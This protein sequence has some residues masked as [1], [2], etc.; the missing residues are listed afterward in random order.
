MIDRQQLLAACKRRYQLIKVPGL[1]DVR[2]RSLTELE[3]STYEA[4]F[5]SGATPEELIEAKRS[6]VI[7][8]VV[9]ADGNP[10]LTTA[11]IKALGEVDGAI[12]GSLFTQCKEFAGIGTTEARLEE[13]LGNLKGTGGSGSP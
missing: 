4:D 10:L 5:L 9:D 8:C 3:R 1:G 11:D 12:L 13:I 7:L 6:L 2:I